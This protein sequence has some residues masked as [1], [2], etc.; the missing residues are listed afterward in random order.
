[1]LVASN[2]CQVSWLRVSGT[3][4][5]LAGPSSLASVSLM[6]LGLARVFSWFNFRLVICLADGSPS[7]F[8][9]GGWLV[10]RYFLME[11]GVKQFSCHYQR[12]PK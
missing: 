9:L 6:F 7:F 2:I 8:H 4:A 5:G 12:L 10:Q 11:L 1:M 3:V